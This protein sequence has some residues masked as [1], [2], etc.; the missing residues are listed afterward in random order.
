MSYLETS[1]ILFKVCTRISAISWRISTI[2]LPGSSAW[3]AESILREKVEK[4]K[5]VEQ[6]FSPEFQPAPL[7]GYHGGWKVHLTWQTEK[8]KYYLIFRFSLSNWTFL[9][10]NRPF[11]SRNG[12]VMTLFL[13][14]GYS[15][16]GQKKGRK[17]APKIPF[18]PRSRFTMGHLKI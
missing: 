3:W 11:S 4:E 10:K 8:I 18:Y 1:I 5:K 17:T 6:N 7:T 14:C 9:Q 12:E 16:R 13:I 2:P 15:I